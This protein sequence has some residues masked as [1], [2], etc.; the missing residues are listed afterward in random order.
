MRDVQEE[1]PAA[2]ALPQ[3]ANCG[4]GQRVRQIIARAAVGQVGHVGRLRAGARCG[5][6]GKPKR[7]RL[8]GAVHGP[9]PREAV[10]LRLVAVGAA[11]MPLAEVAGLVAGRL[12]RLGQCDLLGRQRDAGAGADP[13]ADAHA[14]RHLARQQRRACRRADGTRRVERR[15][16]HALAREPVEVRRVVKPRAVSTQIGGAEV[17]DQQQQDIWPLRWRGARRDQ[18]ENE[19]GTETGKGAKGH[20]G[21]NN[22]QRAPGRAAGGR[23]VSTRAGDRGPA[24]IAAHRGTILVPAHPSSLRRPH[25]TGRLRRKLRLRSFAHQPA[26]SQH[27]A[28]DV[29][30]DYGVVRRHR[31]AAALAF[32][33]GL[34]RD[35]LLH[36]VQLPENDWIAV[37]HRAGERQSL[38]PERRGGRSAPARR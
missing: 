20:R 1:R 22:G 31:A 19:Q 2:L 18:D 34:I 25:R 9:G 3:V 11:E 33:P 17:V 30:T 7:G 36:P 12:Q 13:I 27:H 38:S 23:R 28:A 16:P 32:E 29:I 8:P 35:D 14:L 26:D 24:A 15:P 37:I 10:M 5:A 21:Q 6:I 4:V